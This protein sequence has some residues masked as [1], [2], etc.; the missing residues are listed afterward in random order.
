LEFLGISEM[1][2]GQENFEVYQFGAFRLDANRRL[3][4]KD[5]APVQLT[6]RL[7]DTLRVLVQRGS[8]VV[9]K[10]ELMSAIWGE[11]VVE[12]TNLTTNISLLRKLLGEKK[13]E[14]QYIV[15]VPGEG[16]RFVAQV[17]RLSSGSLPLVIHERTHAAVTIEEEEEERTEESGLDLEI[18]RSLAGA[19]RSH[20]RGVTVG[21]ISAGLLTIILSISAY[22]LLPLHK[23]ATLRVGKVTRLTA[24]GN[25]GNV[26][27]ISP[28]G[29]LFAYSQLEK[30]TQSLWLGHVN[31]GELVRI[32]GP[33]DGI[34]MS[35]TFAPDG[36]SLY[37]TLGENF[38]SSEKQ[39][40]FSLYRLPVFGGSS[41]KIRDNVRNRVAFSPDGSRFAYVRNQ[42]SQ[43]ALMVVDLQNAAEQEIIKPA[44]KLHFSAHSPAWSPD[45]STI[46]V[47]AS[48]DGAESGYEVF[49]VSVN[50]HTL[51]PLTGHKWSEVESIEWRRDGSY[52]IVAAKDRNVSL[53]QLW[54]VSYPDGETQQMVADLA[55]YA[56]AISLASDNTSLVAIQV[57]SQ[58]NIWVAPTGDL[59]KAKQVTFS[60]IG[61]QDGYWGLDWTADGRLLY[62]ARAEEGWRVWIAN[63][64]GSEQR[65]LTPT[66]GTNN[67]PGLTKDGRYLIFQSDRDGRYAIWRE[68]LADHD[69]RRLTNTEI[70]AQP[71]LSPD[72]MWIVYV[73]TPGLAASEG[74]G[75]L[76]RM[77]VAGGEAQRLT[78][79]HTNWARVSP[80]S[81]FIA[82]GYEDDGKMKLAVLPIT[83]GA[84]VKLFDLPRL[85]NLRFSIR[86]TPDGKAVTYRDWA[87]GIWRQNL[88]GGEPERL[89]GLP[90]EKLYGYSWSR[91]GKFFAF[92]R[93]ATSRD[94][95]LLAVN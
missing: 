9:S 6:P 12:E 94:V 85:A 77:S 57:R 60:S 74:L 58:S 79:K 65:Q 50:E 23:S 20:R 90:P 8:G 26:A 49:I 11:S 61:P 34:Y 44:G 24:T 71:D 67:F 55:V 45:G 38:G 84:P 35:L 69:L 70:A 78:D 7:F 22:K 37:Y 43:T 3:L 87:N 48:S 68:D 32:H 42:A 95:T 15:T 63:A 76:Y 16:Y 13:D 39:S 2:N 81:K 33:V 89:P 28:D 21:L 14:H 41:E 56:S 51:K 1:L 91:D 17:R 19:I 29:K 59:S 80:D 62:T 54:S 83:G 53:R 72:G 25:I 18:N 75:T 30:E 46:A 52:L 10:D 36:S 64:D 40:G 66:G 73:S 86:W 82:C 92:T 4:I 27:A 31:G 47:G 5:D 93:A 88:S